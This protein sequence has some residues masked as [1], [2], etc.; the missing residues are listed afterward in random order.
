MVMCSEEE[1]VVVTD[2]GDCESALYST[3]CI[4]NCLVH[5]LICSFVPFF[6]APPPLPL[7]IITFFRRRK[8][9][10]M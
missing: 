6:H 3:S 5:G 9:M 10:G 8:A 4:W 1:V 2:P 7:T